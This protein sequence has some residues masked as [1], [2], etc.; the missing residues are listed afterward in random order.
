MQLNNY[1]VLREDSVSRRKGASWWECVHMCDL[2]KKEILVQSKWMLPAD[3]V[4]K[5]L[6]IFKMHK[7]NFNYFH[8]HKSESFYQRGWSTT[9]RI[10]LTSSSTQTSLD[11]IHS[12]IPYVGRVFWTNKQVQTDS[13]QLHICHHYII[14]VSWQYF[15]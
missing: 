3:E 14:M 11:R 7:L 6:T 2:V 1:W 4:R 13:H 12:Y 9:T 8:W 10:W 5:M 15:L